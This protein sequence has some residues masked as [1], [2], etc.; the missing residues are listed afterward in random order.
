[1]AEVTG[2][3]Q[4][5]IR[6]PDEAGRMTTQIEKRGAQANADAN[7]FQEGKKPILVFSEADG[8]GRSYHAAIGSGSENARRSHYLVQGGWRADKAVQGFGRTHRTNQASAPIF[9]LV[10]TDLQGQ[11]RFISSIAR[12][13]GQLGAL[14]KG[15][16][17]TGDQG[18]FGIGRKLVR[19][20]LDSYIGIKANDPEGYMAARLA[21]SVAGAQEVFRLYGTLKFDGATYNY[22]DLNG[23]VRA[24]VKSLGPEVHDF[25]WWV[26][27]HR[28]ER[29]K[30][31]DREHLFSDQDIATLKQLN[32]SEMTTPYPSPTARPRT[33]GKR[34]TSMR[35]A[36]TM[37]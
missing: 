16:R 18:L 7:S 31:E 32:R 35:C 25:L 2:R 15:E 30:E 1:V 3:G 22:K 5:V 24:L 28:A 12:R 14:T 34:P 17:R 13:L 21:N 20:T 37:P 36:A 27:A 33:A 10:T 9:H 29:L 6:A 4:R 19:E 8:T 23:G 11:K 26:A